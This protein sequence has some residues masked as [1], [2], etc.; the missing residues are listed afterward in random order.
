[1]E[2][3]GGSGI[4]SALV[5]LF[6]RRKAAADG[7]G[8]WTVPLR[9]PV[10][11]GG[12]TWRLRKNATEDGRGSFEGRPDR[13][14]RPRGRGEIGAKST[15]GPVE[16]NRSGLAAAAGWSSDPSPR[17]AGERAPVGVERTCAG[18]GSGD[19]PVRS[20]RPCQGAPWRGAKPRRATGRP[21]QQ[22]RGYATDSALEQ[23]LETRWK[24]E[25]ARVAVTRY[26]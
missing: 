2:R 21:R 20:T 15:G 25:R 9:W 4:C 16:R 8:R 11:R 18:D 13:F 26:G 5:M 7:L 22:W 6:R 10:R 3:A 1:M 24:G 12:A 23:G 17:S 19:R 14:F